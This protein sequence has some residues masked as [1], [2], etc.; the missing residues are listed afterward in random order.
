MTQK[1]YRI[2]KT[3]LIPLGL[4][5]AMLMALLLLSIVYKG[6]PTERLVLTAFFIPS[7]VIFFEALSRHVTAGDQE[8]RIKKFLREKSFQWHEITH[9]GTMTMRKKIYFLLTTTK[10]FH[11]LSN[12]YQDYTELIRHL[13]LHLD[14]E[15]VE[16]EVRA[17]IENP[18][19][20]ISDIIAA[21]F[22]VAAL[23]G[24]I[25]M[26]VVPF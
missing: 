3:F 21:W 17:Q 5:V 11:V 9:I 22:A 15:K 26:K 8:I 16:D 14:R 2:R 25:T 1:I 10:G 18:V 7:A 12:A 13:D 4:A 19:A 6:T 23:L 24:I 20:N